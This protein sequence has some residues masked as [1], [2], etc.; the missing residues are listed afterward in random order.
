M[1]Q[2]LGAADAA[3]VIACTP[4]SPRA[5][6]APVVAAVGDGLGLVAEAVPSVEEAVRRA[7]AVA[8]PDDLVLVSGSF[9]VVGEARGF[10]ARLDDPTQDHQ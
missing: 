5:I 9:Y 1:L 8:G 10:L 4:D 6:P 3:M 2:A 7:L